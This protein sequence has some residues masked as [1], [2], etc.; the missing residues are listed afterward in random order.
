MAAPDEGLGLG[1]EGRGRIKSFYVYTERADTKGRSTQY[2]SPHS[3]LKSDKKCNFDLAKPF[4][5]AVN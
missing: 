1:E 2:T 4:D 5:R 3:I